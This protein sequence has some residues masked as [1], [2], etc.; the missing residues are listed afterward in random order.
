MLNAAKLAAVSTVVFVL[1][2]SADAQ[3]IDPRCAKHKFRDQI[4]CTCAVQNGGVIIP[5]TGGGWR[6]V[7]RFGHRQV[8]EGFVQ[9]MRRNGR[10]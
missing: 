3:Q 4:G 2:T 10:G 5:R 9:C 6:W 7:S 1:T 8:N